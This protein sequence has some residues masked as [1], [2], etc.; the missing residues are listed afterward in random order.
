[1]DAESW[2]HLVDTLRGATADGRHRWDVSGAA[3]VLRLPHGA[4]V[5]V[6]GR[7]DLSVALEV[8]G[9]GGDV[10][11]RLD[12][13]A[14]PGGAPVADPGPV[15]H[16]ADSGAVV[17]LGGQSADLVPSVLALVGEIWPRQDVPVS[18]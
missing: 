14:G 17:D 9:P 7:A 18:A 3:A 6:R 2:T 13:M 12:V 11:D 4:V 15:V 1:M 5:L 8:R 16:L 10:L